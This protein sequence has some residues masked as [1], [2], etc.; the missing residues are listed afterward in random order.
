[1]FSRQLILGILLFLI[2]V[3]PLIASAQ[4]R[5][6]NPYRSALMN[7]YERGM[8]TYRNLLHVMR[9]RPNDMMAIMP[10]YLQY[11]TMR[12][13]YAAISRMYYNWERTN[14]SR[15][16]MSNLLEG[17]PSTGHRPTNYSQPSHGPTGYTPISST[18]KPQTIH[19][20]LI[21]SENIMADVVLKVSQVWS[22]SVPS[23]ST[24]HER[25]TNG[26]IVRVVE[27]EACQEEGRQCI[28]YTLQAMKE[29]KV[30]YTLSSSGG[31]QRELNFAITV[32]NSAFDDSRRN[33]EQP[34][35]YGNM[36]Y[37][38]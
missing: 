7:C 10:V 35:D 11:T 15:G 3:S 21:D 31:Q 6:Q 27:K 20:G 24:W 14:R 33:D 26:Q 36:H 18:T 9:T 2:A 8:Y 28:K 5:G 30:Q 19:H 29:G 1:M 38:Y 4:W 17:R 37:S 13:R 23:G 22:F 32:S 12:V 34:P 16:Y 25:L